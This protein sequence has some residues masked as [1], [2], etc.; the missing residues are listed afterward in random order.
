MLSVEIYII[1]D[2]Y[3]Y[4]LINEIYEFIFKKYM[5]V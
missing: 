3:I 1:I 2:V 4:Y 5:Y